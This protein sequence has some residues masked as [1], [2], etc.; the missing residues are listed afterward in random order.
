MVALF[1]ASIE[2][3][4]MPGI[5]VLG[6]HVS[7]A[8]NYS[9]DLGAPNLCQ[10]FCERKFEATRIMPAAVFMI[11]KLI[12]FAL[13]HISKTSIGIQLG[14]TPVKHLSHFQVPDLEPESQR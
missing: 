6:T 5:M 9:F 12:T 11:G 3:A 13:K 8:P 1:T 7:A 4:I 10:R 2:A 14:W